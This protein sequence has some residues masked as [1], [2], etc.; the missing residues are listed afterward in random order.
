MAAGIAV[1]A[2]CLVR[3]GLGS[4]DDTITG[5][6]AAFTYA[7]L[8]WGWHEM[9]FFMGYVTGPRRVASPPGISEW[10]RFRH[11]VAACLWHEL[12]IVATAIVVVAS[13]WGAPKQVG[14]WTFLAL[15][16]MCTSAKL[17]FFLG[18]L[19]LS[20]EFLPPISPTSKASSAS[21]R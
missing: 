16:G 12:A 13:T 5:A 7:V 19:N 8:A 18:V 15:W 6:Y 11:G 9:S 10:R 2:I 21:A 1:F 3:L 4:T 20:E 17:K 14:T